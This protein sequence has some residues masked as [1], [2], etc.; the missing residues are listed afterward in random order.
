M[1]ELDLT[2]YVGMSRED[3]LRTAV[4]SWK[5]WDVHCI[6]VMMIQL[7]SVMMESNIL[8]ISDDAVHKNIE[9]IMEWALWGI[10][11]VEK[12]NV[13]EWRKKWRKLVE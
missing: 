13:N 3:A 12:I 2:Q 11:P 6:A 10:H 9:R 7:L 5:H 8:D 4:K 1:I